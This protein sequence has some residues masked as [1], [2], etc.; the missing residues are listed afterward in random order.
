MTMTA[1]NPPK[2]LLEITERIG[3]WH[4]MNIRGLGIVDKQD[5]FP[6]NRLFLLV[7]L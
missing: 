2:K 3:H 6:F 5:I 4:A 1:L 7:I